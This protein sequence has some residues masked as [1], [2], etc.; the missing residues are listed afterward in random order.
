MAVMMIM[1]IMMMVMMMMTMMRIVL[2]LIQVEIPAQLVSE[3]SD[4]V[5]WQMWSAT[6]ISVWQRVTTST[7]IRSWDILCL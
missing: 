7:Q 3:Y 5:R 1:V 4:W 2:T 6:F